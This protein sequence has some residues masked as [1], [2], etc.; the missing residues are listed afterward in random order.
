MS[1][2]KIKRIEVLDGLR[3]IAVLIVF[4]SHSS[5][6][7]Q[8][9]A[10]F[11]NFHGIGHIG[12]YLFFTLSAFL[13]GL[14]IFS[15]S[16]TS[17]NIKSFFIKRSLRIIPLYYTI[18]T[19]I[20]LFQVIFNH[21]S[22][23]YLHVSNGWSGYFEHLYF[24]RG[25]GVFWSIVAEVQFYLLVP[26]LAWLILKFKK[27]AIIFL[28]IVATVNFVLYLL[29][30]GQ[31]TEFLHYLSP[32]TLK[33]GTFIDIFL[34]GLILSYFVIFKNDL[35]HKYKDTIHKVATVL[36][37]VGSFLTISLV[38]RNFL[39][40]HRPLFAFRFL[41]LP[42]AIGFSIITLSLYMGNP[43]MTRFFKMHFLRF[44]GKIG[45]SFYLLHMVIFE[46]VNQFSIH[47]TIKFFLSFAIIS[48]VS[49]I[50]YIIIEKPSIKL[51]Y[52]LINKLGYR[53][54][55]SEENKPTFKQ[56]S[57]QKA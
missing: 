47:H 49:Y 38:S 43:K 36:F 21:Y 28:S 29:K 1:L 45:F 53:S 41:S 54:S 50:F 10:S 35:L 30:Y 24:Y 57:H 44:I 8:S 3:G 16:L 19:G 18:V 55:I 14:G 52:N 51:S 20:F 6:R 12:V 15:K 46:I 48:L 39:G 40:F 56:L 2:S 23:T 4:L 25:D 32:N 7:D 31:V 37:I 5:G 11:L 9:M 42:F 33:R 27:K 22:P 34:P 26:I 17:N 13:L